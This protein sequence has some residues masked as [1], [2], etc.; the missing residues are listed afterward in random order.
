MS[1]R[2]VLNSRP[3]ARDTALPAEGA[4]EGDAGSRE[5]LIQAAARLFA[6][7]G[8]DGVSVRQ[9]AAAAEANSALVG[10]YF[11]GKDGLLSEVYRRLSEPLTR[12]RMRLLE[13]CLAGGRTPRL[14]EVIE[15]FV[16]PALD[17]TRGP[18]GKLFTRLR[19]MLAGRHSDLLDRVVA[20]SFDRSTLRFVEVL[21]GCLPHLLRDEVFW[22]F[23]FLLGAIYYTAAGP[24]RVKVL[25]DGRCDPS[26]AAAALPQLVRHAAAG[27]R[28]PSGDVAPA[29]STGG[30]RRTGTP[31]GT[32]DDA[33]NGKKAT[34]TRASP[35]PRAMRRGQ[36]R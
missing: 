24:H 28:A 8:F 2:V 12:E 36:E 33:E 15:A 6:E 17:A 29:S 25:S 4:P 31:S 3:N 34:G 19:A 13:A 22:R 18:E 30:T 10:Y 11:R 20:E 7:H 35:R 5:R 1:Y 32:K 26:D 16:R 27:F 14:E 9:I 23:H 21:Q